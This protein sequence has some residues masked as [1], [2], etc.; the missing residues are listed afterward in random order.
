MT[1][2]ATK[3][4]VTNAA[5]TQRPLAV[6]LSLQK[7]SHSNRKSATILSTSSRSLAELLACSE[8]EPAGEGILASAKWR[9]KETHLSQLV[10]KVWKRVFLH[11]G[12]HY[13][14]VAVGALASLV[15]I[16]PRRQPPANLSHDLS[17]SSLSIH[18]EMQL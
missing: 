14:K 3:T 10:G 8:P 7:P 17:H 5:I 16:Q 2:M 9:S 6:W 11:L 12:S 1:L 15:L 4:I 18:V 13:L